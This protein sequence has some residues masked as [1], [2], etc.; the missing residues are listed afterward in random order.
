MAQLRPFAELYKDSRMASGT[1]ERFQGMSLR[2]AERQN[3]P[4]AAVGKMSSAF[5]TRCQRKC[6]PATTTLG[7]WQQQR[8][9]T[10]S[11]DRPGPCH[12][13]ACYND[14]QHG[15]DQ[16]QAARENG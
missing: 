11:D 8:R 14:C 1:I 3:V 4:L 10:R 9:Q 16:H 7:F 13:N 12:P 6:S 2:A 5:P 15:M